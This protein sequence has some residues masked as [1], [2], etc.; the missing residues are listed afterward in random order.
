MQ[1]SSNPSADPRAPASS[2]PSS[3]RGRPPW[4]L[5]RVLL[6]GSIPLAAVAFYAVLISVPAFQ[7]YTHDGLAA[8]GLFPTRYD[9]GCREPIVT[10]HGRFLWGGSDPDDHF[11]ITVFRLDTDRLHYGLGRER[12]PALVEPRFV[13]VAEILAARP[14]GNMGLSLTGGG[15]PLTAE[16]NPKWPGDLAR[17]LTVKVGDDVR[18]YPLT[19]L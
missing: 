3:T 11:D 14:E 13:P 6:A 12:F 1:Q 10:E 4:N 8:L 17:V 9:P 18:I 7:A 2:P 15:K 19:V 5:G 16:T